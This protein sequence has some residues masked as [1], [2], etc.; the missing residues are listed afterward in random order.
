MAS[1]E[2]VA[3]VVVTK[4]EETQIGLVIENILTFFDRVILVN[5]LFTD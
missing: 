2:T 5:D 3:N 4:N 1:Y